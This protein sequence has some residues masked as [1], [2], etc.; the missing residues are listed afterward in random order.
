MADPFELAEPIQRVSIARKAE[1][2]IRHAIVTGVLKSGE[3][4]SP[5]EIADRLGVSRTP[6]REAIIHL[7]AVGLVEMLPN[8][9]HIVSPT[10][11]AIQDSFE[12]REALESMA[13]RLAAQRRTTE[14]AATILR[15]AE[16]TREA[17]AVG[18]R[19]GFQQFDRSFHLAVGEASHSGYVDR[20]L[21]YALDLAFTLRNLR[22]ANT[23]FSANAVTDHLEI[24]HAIGAQDDALAESVSRRHIRAVLNAVTVARTEAAG[25]TRGNA[26]GIPR[27]NGMDL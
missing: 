6:I 9:V 2:L 21:S 24:A 3:Q 8:R 12:L 14:Q 11:T 5:R 7:N 13:A 19:L 4:I 10:T 17:A 15:L 25:Q 18:D 26:P 23:T 1:E 27:P 20:Y 16:Q 22:V